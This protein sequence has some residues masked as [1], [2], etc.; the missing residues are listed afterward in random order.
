VVYTRT[1]KVLLLRRT[2]PPDFWQSVT[3]TME[4]S[5]T[6]PRATAVREL[7]EEAGLAV[8]A[9]ELR[10]LG[11]TNRFEILPPWRHRYAP[12]VNENIEHV[13]ALELAR[14]TALTIHP[15]EHAEYG[16]FAPG[17]A[18]ERAWSWT[19]REAIREATKHLG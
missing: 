19:D 5:E 6:D 16:W 4:W 3:G 12:E 8:A 14:E 13:F 7:M 2:E 1:R 11:I 9:P 18:A 17:Q 10:D 15:R